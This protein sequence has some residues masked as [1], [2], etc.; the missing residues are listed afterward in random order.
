LIRQRTSSLAEYKL[1][2]A[3][4]FGYE[5]RDNPT[6]KVTSVASRWFWATVSAAEGTRPVIVFAGIFWTQFSSLASSGTTRASHA[7]SFSARTAWEFRYGY[8]NS[9]S[10]VE[11]AIG[12]FVRHF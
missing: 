8:N 2:L 4:E 9:I 5:L 12:D 10:F 6:E 1:R 3:K 7:V 11:D